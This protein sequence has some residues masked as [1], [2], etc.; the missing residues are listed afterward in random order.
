[1]TGKGNR[2][3]EFQPPEVSVY[4]PTD[5]QILERFRLSMPARPR[6]GWYQIRTAGNDIMH[7]AKT[8]R[9]TLAEDVNDFMLAMLDPEQHTVIIRVSTNYQE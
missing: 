4:N 2:V 1:M 8:V 9:L 5:R 3:N 7:A 6:T